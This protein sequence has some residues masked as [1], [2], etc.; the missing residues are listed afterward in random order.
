MRSKRTFITGMILA[1][2]FLVLIPSVSQAG[3]PVRQGSIVGSPQ[4]ADCEF[5]PNCKV[6]IASGCNA[7]LASADNG[8][9]SSIV[10]IQD[11]A[12]S[13][14]SFRLL[15]GSPTGVVWSVASGV[16]IQFWSGTCARVTPS[17]LIPLIKPGQTLTVI[18]PSGA[19]WMVVTAGSGFN[20]TWTLT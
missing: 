9:A 14:R 6:F 17:P 3:P 10:N 11:I 8:V 19:R 20:F 18:I 2:S 15:L 13:Q 4:F 7:A 5:S 1:S 16:A 12:G